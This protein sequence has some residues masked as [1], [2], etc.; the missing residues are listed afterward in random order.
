MTTLK[1]SL[2]WFSIVG[3]LGCMTLQ[4]EDLRSPEDQLIHKMSA[5]DE[6]HRGAYNQFKFRA[7]L[8]TPEVAQTIIEKKARFYQWSPVK[9]E[10]ALTQMR[11]KQSVSIEVFISFFTPEYRD[12][13]MD[14][15][16]S[17]WKIY[18]DSN[19]NRYEGRV[20]KDTT[21]FTELQNL[22]PY[23]ARFN[24][25]YIATFEIPAARVDYHSTSMTIT[26]PLGNKTVKFGE[27]QEAVN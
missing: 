27:S 24:S 19:G 10:E 9:R 18:L 21:H 15:K 22:I 20:K 23:H 12:N 5:G 25:P 7:T 8:L 26:G 4:N 3:L 1:S 13:N 16:N 14:Q 11:E 17:I 6:T 2:A